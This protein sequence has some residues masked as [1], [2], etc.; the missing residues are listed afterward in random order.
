MEFIFFSYYKY[1]D[2]WAFIV[3]RIKHVVAVY[4]AG[5]TAAGIRARHRRSA[6]FS[7][8]VHGPLQ[9]R[10][11]ASWRVVLLFFSLSLSLLWSASPGRPLH[12]CSAKERDVVRWCCGGGAEVEVRQSRWL[13]GE[14]VP[15][16]SVRGR[17]NEW[18]KSA[19]RVQWAWHRCSARR[20]ARATT[21]AEISFN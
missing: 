5:K 8:S 11:S 1:T 19:S 15:A 21:A 7:R 20:V 12:R 10:K 18:D 14:R 17:K 9:R 16:R 3:I 6:R 4:V 13:P 2:F